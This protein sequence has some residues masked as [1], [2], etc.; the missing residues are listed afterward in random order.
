MKDNTKDNKI[1]YDANGKL[2][3]IKEVS[4]DV[5]CARK[6]LDLAGFDVKNLSDNE[7]AS[8]AIEQSKRYGVALLPF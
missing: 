8:L 5:S 2:L 7:V 4:V 3:V 1:M 6:I